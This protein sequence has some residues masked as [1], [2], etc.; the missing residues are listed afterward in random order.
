MTDRDDR[1]IW[2]RV[3][4][5]YNPPEETPAEEIWAR[6]ERRIASDEN[7]QG[8]PGTIDLESAR[9]RRKAW[10][11]G[12]GFH[13]AVGW[14]VAAAALVVMGV[15]I[16]RMTAPVAPVADGSST[17]PAVGGS[18]GNVLAA[19]AHLGRTEA[20][21]TMVRADARDGRVDPGVA[22]W[23]DDLLTETR[24]LLDRP[25]GVDPELRS[26][27]LDLEL[28]LVQV[29]GMSGAAGDDARART[30][31]EL[32][33]RSLDQGEVLPRIQAQLP[34]VMSGA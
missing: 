1:E 5:G 2:A 14:A 27:L 34:R 16:G 8:A 28:V 21:L 9:R 15:G 23:A 3:G 24:L 29:A 11:V 13:K 33:L 12:P 18:S 6:I 20:L 4:E 7:P 26:L 17:Q 22:E 25:T 10:A 30:E 19:R 31:V 32:T